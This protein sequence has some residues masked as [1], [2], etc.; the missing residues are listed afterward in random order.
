[1][2]IIASQNN[3]ITE[4][5]EFFSSYFNTT[6]VAMRPKAVAKIFLELRAGGKVMDALHSREAKENT[7]K[8]YEKS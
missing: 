1:M 3:F 7:Y 6:A 2:D 5:A 4:K 8:I